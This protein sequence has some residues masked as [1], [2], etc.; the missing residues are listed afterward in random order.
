M[1]VKAEQKQEQAE[2]E[3]TCPECNGKMIVK[4]SRY[5]MF[6]AC[7]NYPECKHTEKIENGYVKQIVGTCPECGGELLKRK[8]RFGEFIGCSNY[9]ECRYTEKTKQ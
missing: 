4:R 3:K 2:Q 6:M 5:G 8:S 1:S 7:E 9:P